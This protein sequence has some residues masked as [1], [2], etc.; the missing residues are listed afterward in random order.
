MVEGGRTRRRSSRVVLVLLGGMSLAACGDGQERQVYASPEDCREEWGE[1]RC[2]PAGSG[3][4]HGHTYGP[5]Y[6]R[7]SPPQRLGPSGAQPS[8]AVG[9]VS[10]GGF[11]RSAASHGAHS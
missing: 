5:S 6:H 4:P 2:E 11:G 10:R 8:K 1:E 9:T 3:H 7:G